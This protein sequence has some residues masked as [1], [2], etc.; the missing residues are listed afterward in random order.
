MSQSER[1]TTFAA[2]FAEKSL[3]VEERFAALR[4]SHRSVFGTLSILDQRM[5]ILDLVDSWE[6]NSALES[7]GTSAPGSNTIWHWKRERERPSFETPLGCY[8]TGFGPPAPKWKKKRQSRKIG[9]TR[10]S[11]SVQSLK[12]ALTKARFPRSRAFSYFMR[13]AEVFLK[14]FPIQACGARNL[15]GR[16]QL[17]QTSRID[18]CQHQEMDHGPCN[19]ESMT[20]PLQKSLPDLKD[21]FV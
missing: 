8:G 6:R 1:I 15:F 17:P 14:F 11:K 3:K 9:R 10:F 16:T 13:E 5:K 12:M 21:I 4:S 2:S 7:S 20:V 19:I 18:A